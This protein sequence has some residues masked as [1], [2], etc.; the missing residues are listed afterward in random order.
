MLLF[1][2]HFNLT[3]D[4]IEDDNFPNDWWEFGKSLIDAW[5]KRGE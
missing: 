3:K 4:E 5:W 1:L 2:K